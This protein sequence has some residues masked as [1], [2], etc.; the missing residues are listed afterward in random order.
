MS[1]HQSFL[2]TNKGECQG[3]Q[4]RCALR[5]MGACPKFGALG[6]EGRDGRRRVPGCGDPVAIGRRNR[7]GGLAKQRTAAR[8]LGVQTGKFVASNEESWG[9]MFANEIK[10]GK[11]VG[12]VANWWRKVEAQVLANEA[13]HGAIRK[14]VR[15]V[16]MPEGMTDGLVVI[17]LSAWR[18]HVTPALQEFYGDGA[19]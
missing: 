1:E 17:R 11:Q 10:S 5:V 3:N 15:A 19:A 2:K 8:A 4:D 12:P 14:P 13:D 9:G 7:K 18:E 16:A 6:R